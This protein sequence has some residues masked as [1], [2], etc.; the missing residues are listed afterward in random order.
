MNILSYNYELVYFHFKNH[1]RHIRNIEKNN[2]KS[3]PMFLMEQWDF[4]FYVMYY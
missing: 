2:L 3:D 1:K 4:P